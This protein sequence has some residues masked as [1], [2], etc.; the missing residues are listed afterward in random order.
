MLD[1]VWQAWFTVSEGGGRME[2]CS[3]AVIV[4]RSRIRVDKFAS[5]S[6]AQYFVDKFNASPFYVADVTYA[7]IIPICD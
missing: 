1:K 6:D 4:N 3:V 2:N 5:E 7:Q